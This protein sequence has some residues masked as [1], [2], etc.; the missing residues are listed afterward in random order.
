MCCVLPNEN[1]QKLISG[2][3]KIIE[4]N[5]FFI[6]EEGEDYLR[7]WSF[8]EGGGGINRGQA[9]TWGEQIS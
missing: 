4:I 9:T 1:L 6:R 8:L 5:Y 2:L 7:G 3:Q